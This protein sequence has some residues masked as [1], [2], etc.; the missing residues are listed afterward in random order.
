M[1]QTIP[2]EFQALLQGGPRAPVADPYPLYARLRRESPVLPIRG[3]ERPHFA[4]SRYDDIREVLR[5]EGLFSS[6]ANERGAGLVFGRTIIGMDGRDH[7]LHRSLITPALA[8][9][10]LRGDFPQL[11]RKL[12]HAIIDEFAGGGEADLVANF[13]FAYPLRVFVEILGLPPQDL[14]AFHQLAID[15]TL[16]ASDPSKAF[17]ASSKIRDLLTP[18]VAEKRRQ[19]G[20]DLM[21]HLVL[22][23]VEG[24][25]LSD[26]DLVSFLRLLVS[27]GAETTFHLMGGA[28][29]ALLNDPAL[30]ARVRND[31]ALIDPVL[32]ETL[33]WEAP[34][35]LL[36][37]EATADCEIAGVEIPKG[38]DLMLL[39]GSANRDEAKFPD[40]DRFDIDRDNKDQIGFGL[41][42]HY[43]AGSRLA[44]LEGR[45]GL[46]A[47]LDRLDDLRPRAT[48]PAEVIGFAFR[49]PST[50]PV[51]FRPSEATPS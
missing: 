1:A 45:I 47:L 8:P 18:L 50:L 22:A 28:L 43:C 6:R 10:A 19:P 16:I 2:P 20:D 26:D 34:V 33:R 14:E 27:A 31:R 39:L 38:S 29:C 12:A 36:P 13:T 41:G 46:D 44:L 5:N 7:L 4:L 51:H 42:K 25:R 11:V 9:R 30:L 15:L 35:S 3:G 17:E 32:W 48:E 23:E 49:G 37:R 24:E 21:S 40:P